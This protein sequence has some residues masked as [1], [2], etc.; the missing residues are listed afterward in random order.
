MNDVSSCHSAKAQLAVTWGGQA[1][2]VTR[3][4]HVNAA[5]K[6]VQVLQQHFSVGEG[7]Q[8]YLID[9]KPPLPLPVVRL[10]MVASHVL[11][12]GF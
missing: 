5:E 12:V 2:P 3:L 7:L 6:D 8:L 11:V 1:C 4:C 10:E 9:F